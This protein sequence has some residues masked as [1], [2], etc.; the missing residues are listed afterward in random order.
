MMQFHGTKPQF[1]MGEN[2]G[3][4]VIKKFT[5]FYGREEQNRKNLDLLLSHPF[6]IDLP[7][8]DVYIIEIQ[9]IYFARASALKVSG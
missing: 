9:L 4:F 2:G 6:H 5:M 7:K 1:I 3:K 8:K